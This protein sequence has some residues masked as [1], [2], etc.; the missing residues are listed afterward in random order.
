MEVM[1]AGSQ[2]P[3]AREGIAAFLEKRTPEWPTR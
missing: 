1:A 3:E 2:T